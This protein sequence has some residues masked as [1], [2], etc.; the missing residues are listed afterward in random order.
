MNTKNRTDYV[1]L[2][3]FTIIFCFTNLLNLLTFCKSEW[4][5][6]R[7]MEMGGE[8]SGKQKGEIS[9]IP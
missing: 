2:G 9:S 5:A 6:K 1:R 8:K 4:G 3:D 7:R